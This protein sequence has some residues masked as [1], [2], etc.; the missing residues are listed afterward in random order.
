MKLYQSVD[1]NEYQNNGTKLNKYHGTKSFTLVT[2][3]GNSWCCVRLFFISNNG[4]N[5][6]LVENWWIFVEIYLAFVA[7]LYL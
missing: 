1:K 6:T 2:D 5:P 4:L 7:S 3:W